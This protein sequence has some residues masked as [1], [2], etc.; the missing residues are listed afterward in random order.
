MSDPTSRVGKVDVV[1]EDRASDHQDHDGCHPRNAHVA[2]VHSCVGIPLIHFKLVRERKS[3]WG[4]SLPTVEGKVPSNDVHLVPSLWWMGNPWF[5]DC[6]ISWRWVIRCRLDR[7][8][9]LLD[10]FF[11]CLNMESFDEAR[12]A[13]DILIYSQKLA[14]TSDVRDVQ[15]WESAVP[16]WIVSGVPRCQTDDWFGFRP[17][18]SRWSWNLLAKL[19]C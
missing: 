10:T 19:T 4:W 1:H 3:I 18:V 11:S 7:I 13:Q 17:L 9:H 6:S 16:L 12:A 14:W 8:I 15:T 2:H 5:K